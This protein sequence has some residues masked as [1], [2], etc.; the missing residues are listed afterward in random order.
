MSSAEKWS[1]NKIAD[2]DFVKKLTQAVFLKTK[3]YQQ[4]RKSQWT[5]DP[6]KTA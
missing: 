5:Q 4:V 6:E 2:T 1:E 3:F